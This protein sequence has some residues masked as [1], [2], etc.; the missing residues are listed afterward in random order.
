MAV[1]SFSYGMTDKR[2]AQFKIS[3][4]FDNRSLQQSYLDLDY[5]YNSFEP[6]VNQDIHAGH[7]EFLKWEEVEF[8]QEVKEEKEHQETGIMH[9]V[10]GIFQEMEV[11]ISKAKKIV[12]A[13]KE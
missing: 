1:Y 6:T 7:R 13:M 2:K 4:F 9:S 5:F 10:S 12:T 3:V 8:V 11:Y